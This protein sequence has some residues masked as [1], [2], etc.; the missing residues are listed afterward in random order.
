MPKH[1]N[2]LLVDA[3]RSATGPEQEAVLQTLVIVAL[4][5]MASLPIRFEGYSHIHEEERPFVYETEL[6]SWSKKGGVRIRWRF[7]FWEGEIEDVRA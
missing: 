1:F 5:E 6:L 3:G 2:L 7:A 4:S